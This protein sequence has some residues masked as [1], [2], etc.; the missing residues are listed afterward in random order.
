MGKF[1]V[2]TSMEMALDGRVSVSDEGRWYRHARRIGGS[3]VS[4]RTR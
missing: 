4:S 3:H 2:G 1:T